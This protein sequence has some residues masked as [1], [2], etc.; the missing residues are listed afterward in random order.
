MNRNDQNNI[1]SLYVENVA[2]QEEMANMLSKHPEAG[3]PQETSYEFNAPEGYEVSYDGNVLTISRNV[4]GT[5]SKTMTGVGKMDINDLQKAVD[6]QVAYDEFINSRIG[7][8]PDQ[9]AEAK[10]KFLAR[11]KEIYRK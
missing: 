5:Y 2:S 7:A 1:A 3:K 6:Y 11:G 10:K 9:A 4:G 8:T